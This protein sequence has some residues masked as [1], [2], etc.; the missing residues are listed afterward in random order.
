[1]IVAVPKEVR[2]DEQ[3]VALVPAI[4]SRLVN[5]GFEIRMEAGIGPGLLH[6]LIRKGSGQGQECRFP[7]RLPDKTGAVDLHFKQS[8]LLQ[9]LFHHD[10]GFGPNGMVVLAVDNQGLEFSAPAS[11][12]ESRRTDQHQAPSH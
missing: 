7:L 10:G 4:V 9:V 2:S 11:G 3:R 12:T 8:G 1:M 6:R 5:A